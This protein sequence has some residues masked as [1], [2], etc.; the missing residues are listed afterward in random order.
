[1]LYQLL[2]VSAAIDLD[3]SEIYTTYRTESLYLYI[4]LFYNQSFVYCIQLPY[5]NQ[6]LSILAMTI[7]FV[8]ALGWEHRIAHV[9]AEMCS[10]GRAS[11][12]QMEESLCVHQFNVVS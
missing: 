1:M 10:L 11:S 8:L 5:S 4:D 6:P 3:Y 2:E 7:V 12:I 9:N